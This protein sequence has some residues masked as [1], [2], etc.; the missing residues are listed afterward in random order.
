MEERH[1]TLPDRIEYLETEHAFA[2]DLFLVAEEEGNVIGTIVGGWDGWRGHMA[3]LAIRPES[4]RSGVARALVREV[5]ERLRAKGA[6]RIYAMVDRR[7]ELGKR[8][9]AAAGYLPGEDM[10]QY[11]KN[12]E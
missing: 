5:E 2:P 10:L 4:R 3:R 8:F 1:T 6:L 7:N 9:W 11:A 12:M